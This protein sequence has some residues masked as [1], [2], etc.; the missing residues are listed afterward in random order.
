MTDWTRARQARQMLAFVIN[1]RI[2]LNAELVALDALATAASDYLLAIGAPL[3]A[4]ES[5]ASLAPVDGADVAGERS[6]SPPASPDAPIEAPVLAPAAGESGHADGPVPSSD[7]AGSSAPP[8]VVT[9]AQV[10]ANRGEFVCTCGKRMTWKP[11]FAR[12]QQICPAVQGTA[13]VASAETSDVPC[14]DCSR[15]FATELG[16]KIHRGQQH[17]D[18]QIAATRD[19]DPSEP[20]GVHAASDAATSPARPRRESYLCSRCPL[21]FANVGLLNEHLL[22]DHPKEERGPIPVGSNGGSLVAGVLHPGAG[23][24]LR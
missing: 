11:G 20:D 24:G 4:I 1:R 6:D 8:R 3:E 18:L 15:R 14:P 9:R 7:A 5:P 2:E 17:A 22:R 12:H 10:S 21:A 13:T 16:L 19:A 23:G